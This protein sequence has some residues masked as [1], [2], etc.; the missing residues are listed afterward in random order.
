MQI[1][2]AHAMGPWALKA[3]NKIDR[4]E[5]RIM[6]KSSIATAVASLSHFSHSSAGRRPE[7]QSFPRQK[8]CQQGENK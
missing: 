2:L 3:F 5:V 1:A 4:D 6:N 7:I 8:L